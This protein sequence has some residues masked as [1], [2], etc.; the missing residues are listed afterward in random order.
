[1]MYAARRNFLKYSGV[2]GLISLTGFS[3]F[4]TEPTVVFEPIGLTHMDE[5]FD[6]EGWL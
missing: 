3:L 1:M 4:A 2:W 5:H 6:P